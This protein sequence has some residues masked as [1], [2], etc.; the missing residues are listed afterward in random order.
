MLDVFLFR[1]KYVIRENYMILKRD[2]SRQE[3]VHWRFITNIAHRFLIPRLP[4]ASKTNTDRKKFKNVFHFFP[5][6]T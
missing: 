2:A 4:Y 5:P 1:D 6:N 3:D